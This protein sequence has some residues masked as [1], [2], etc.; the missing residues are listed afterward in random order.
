MRSFTR[1]TFTEGTDL[2]SSCPINRSLQSSTTGPSRERIFPQNYS[3][4]YSQSNEECKNQVTSSF[5]V[6]L[7]SVQKHEK[8]HTWTALTHQAR[9]LFPIGKYP[10]QLHQIRSWQKLFRSQKCFSK[11]NRM[12]KSNGKTA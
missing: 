4:T 1:C 5:I 2:F 6:F 12:S 10:K 7:R 3:K 9:S 11:N 8:I